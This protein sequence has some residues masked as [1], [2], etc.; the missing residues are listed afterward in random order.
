M[1][2]GLDEKDITVSDNGGSDSDG[3][4]LTFTWS[5]GGSISTYV[6]VYSH[7]Y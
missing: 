5:L 1:P 4:S 7:M 6:I 3:D 2:N